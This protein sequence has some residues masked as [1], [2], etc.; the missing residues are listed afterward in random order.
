M[1]EDYT[2]QAVSELLSRGEIQLIDV[3]AEHE[4][5]AGRIAGGRLIE[6]N[7]LSGAAGSVDRGRPVVFYCRSGARSAMAA[8]AFAQ[9]GFDAHNM[10]GGLLEWDAQGLP[11]EPDGGYVADP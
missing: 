10:S 11:I 6:L 9:A 3:R 2:P 8:E 5:Q 1:P 4:H 7:Q